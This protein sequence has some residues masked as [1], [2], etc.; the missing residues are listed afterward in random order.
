MDHAE[1]VEK[2]RANEIEVWIDK[3]EA[4][5]MY[6]DPMLMPR[7]LRAQQAVIRAAAF[8]GSIFGVALFFLS[9]W[10][11]ALGVLL[12][13]FFMFPVAQKAGVRGVLEA[14]LKNPSVYQVAVER[15]VLIAKDIVR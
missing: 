10:W 13:G 9:H 8:G 12:A 6:E 2:Y 5:F 11:L 7:R 4:G 15:Q 14:S 1:F 3:N